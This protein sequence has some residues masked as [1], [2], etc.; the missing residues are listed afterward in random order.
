MARHGCTKGRAGREAVGHSRHVVL[1][2]DF[3][4]VVHP[5]PTAGRTAGLFCSMHLLEEVLREIPEVEVVISS[6]WREHH[7]FEEIREYFAEDL[8]SRVV[9]VTQSLS[10]KRS[11]A[12][13]RAYPRHAECIAWLQRNRLRGT[14]WLALDDSPEEFAPGCTQLIAVDGTEGLTPFV[15]GMLLQ[16]LRSSI[17]GC[18]A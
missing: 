4:G 2:S 7:P 9:G 18:G 17:A 1:F 13:L 6:S 16:R 8:R 12:W 3:D 15:A 5:R 14:Y 11:P 10:H